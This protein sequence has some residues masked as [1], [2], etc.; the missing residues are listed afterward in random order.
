M[1]VVSDTSPI[2]N[3]TQI[4]A[5]HLLR[6]I[7]SVVVIPPSVYDELCELAAQKTFIDHCEWISIRDIHNFAQVELLAQ[8]LD[9]G[10]ASAIALAMELQADFLL[11]DEIKGRNEAEKLGIKVTGIIGVLLRAKAEGLIENV[12]PLMDK[13]I[14]DCNFRIRP[15]LYQKALLLAN[16]INH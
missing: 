5:L 10:E 16:E 9:A 11:M 6:D 2:T 7:F 3:L 12:K 13:L 15:E 8:K 14:N 1:V 4:N